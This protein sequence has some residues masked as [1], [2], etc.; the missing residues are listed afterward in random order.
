MIW[1]KQ[2][3]IPKLPAQY[4]GRVQHQQDAIAERDDRSECDSA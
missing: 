3:K 1:N 4:Q 2:F